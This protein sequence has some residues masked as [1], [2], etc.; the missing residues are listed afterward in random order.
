MRESN[1]GAFYL[2][3]QLCYGKKREEE[4]IFQDADFCPLATWAWLSSV[5]SGRERDP[6]RLSYV[7]LSTSLALRPLWTLGVHTVAGETPVHQV[8][9]KH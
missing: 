3:H 9:L 8:P 1:S 5:F 7:H 4:T 6:S 2:F